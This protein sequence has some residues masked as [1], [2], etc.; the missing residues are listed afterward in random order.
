[1]NS[2][3]YSITLYDTS[4]NFIVF[5]IGSW[6]N[7]F[8]GG[9]DRLTISSGTFEWD[10]VIAIDINE[11][12]LGEFISGVITSIEAVFEDELQP[13]P[14]FPEPEPPF[15]A[16]PSPEVCP[17]CL[18]APFGGTVAINNVYVFQTDYFG[19]PSS[20]DWGGF[21]YKDIN[22][23]YPLTFGSGGSITITARLYPKTDLQDV[24]FY[25]LLGKN[26]YPDIVPYY[27]TNNITLKGTGS[28]VFTN[29]PEQGAREFSSLA[30][31]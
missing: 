4:N 7:L 23:E 2:S 25:L 9:E 8:D 1:M 29:I 30:L 12:G 27:V 3:T 13:N 14:P 28:S 11:G 20:E 19:G 15:W 6:A 24:D 31:L 18:F 21:I 5:S 26:D 17:E 16:I 10:K 22:S